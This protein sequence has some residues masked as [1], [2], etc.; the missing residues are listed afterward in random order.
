MEHKNKAVV[1]GTNYYIGLAVVR[2]LGKKGVHVVSVNHNGFNYY[3]K[4]RY[5]KEAL[6]APHYKTHSEACLSFLINY[7]KNQEEK[8]VLFA[9]ADPWVEFIDK[10]FHELKEYY[11][12]PMDRKGLLTDLMDK[13]KLL[14]FAKKYGVLMPET[15][16]STE[17]NIYERVAKEIKYPCIFKPKDSPTFVNMYREKAFFINN[18]RELKKALEKT[19][20]DRIECFVQRIIPGPE[21]N[22]YNFDC[23]MNQKGKIAYYT[24]EYKIRQWPINFGASTVA[25]QKWIPEA[26]NLAMPFLQALRFKGFVEIEMKRDSENDK[27]YMVEVNVRFVNFT[28]MHVEIGMDTPYLT[29]S[30]MVGE[31]IGEKKIDYDTGARWRY[32]YEDIPAMREYVATGQKQREEI[33]EEN[34]YKNV[35]PSTWSKDDPWPGIKFVLFKILRK[36]GRTFGMKLS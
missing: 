13:Y 15:I 11:L 25:Q 10:Y 8:P 6:I 19:R 16:E 32:L 12:F 35:I 33:I 17:D 9:T 26:A 5:V 21:E 30:E 2:S 28:Q 14:E 22:N 7:A 3:G 29:Y 4:S 23:Y 20:A 1:L 34:R 31:D 18:E 27:I 36:I 24:T